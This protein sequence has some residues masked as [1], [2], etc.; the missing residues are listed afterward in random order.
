MF[1]NI[2]SELSSSADIAVKA[3]VEKLS[4]VCVQVGTVVVSDVLTDQGSDRS[5]PGLKGSGNS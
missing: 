1:A 2:S 5:D 4:P 3:V